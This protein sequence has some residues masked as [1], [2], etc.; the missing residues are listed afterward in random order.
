MITRHLRTHNKLKIETQQNSSVDD[1]PNSHV[2]VI[3]RIGDSDR[4][5]VTDHQTTNRSN[6]T[7]SAIVNLTKIIESNESDNGSSICNK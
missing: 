4:T 7:A 5:L 1:K 2:S 6:E 3:H